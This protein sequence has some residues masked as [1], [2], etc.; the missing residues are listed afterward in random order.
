MYAALYNLVRPILSRGTGE[1]EKG[2]LV[3]IEL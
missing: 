1:T 2:S 3:A